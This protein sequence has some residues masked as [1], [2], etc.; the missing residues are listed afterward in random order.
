MVNVLIYNWKTKHTSACLFI[1]H[2]LGEKVK[3]NSQM[4]IT[5]IYNSYKGTTNAMENL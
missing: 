1:F 2:Y 5:A 3:S 4:E